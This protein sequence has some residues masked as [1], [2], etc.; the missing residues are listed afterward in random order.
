MSSLP[1]AYSHATGS[2]THGGWSGKRGVPGSSKN[3]LPACITIVFS[4]TAVPVHEHT[5]K[6]FRTFSWLFLELKKCCASANKA[7]LCCRIHA[8]REGRRTECTRIRS[9]KCK[10]RKKSGRSS[11]SACSGK[12]LMIF[13]APGVCVRKCNAIHSCRARDNSSTAVLEQKYTHTHSSS[14]TKKNQTGW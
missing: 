3:V 9:S 6:H 14:G 5:P 7:G 8:L 13:K 4:N 2:I 1:R 10:Y 11:A 12:A